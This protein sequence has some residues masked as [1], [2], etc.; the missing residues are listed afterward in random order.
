MAFKTPTAHVQPKR[1]LF[2]VKG[3]PSF[4][5]MIMSRLFGHLD[6]V[7]IYLDDIIIYA[8]TQEELYDKLQEV[9]E[10]LKTNNIKLNFDKCL[11]FQ[12]E[13][14]YLGRIVSHNKIRI[15]AQYIK[16]LLN[17]E[18]PKTKKELQMVLGVI[19][20]VAPWIPHLAHLSSPLHDLKQ[21]HAKW[22]WTPRH[23]EAFLKIK[24]LVKTTN[25]LTPPD[26]TKQF[27]IWLHVCMYV[28][29]YVICRN[30]FLFF[31]SKYVCMYVCML[32]IRASFYFFCVLFIGTSMY[33]CYPL[34]SIQVNNY[35]IH[36][37]F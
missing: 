22:K 35:T 31:F 21:K 17:L 6:K 13:I 9:F 34:T 5:Q 18:E 27:I 24:E 1:M 25:Y 14:E 28:C 36:T 4:Q 37:Y 11:F 8:N 7:Q 26:P 12:K 15:Q 29:M 19:G 2:G 23:T 10:I 30:N 20:W 32:F 16:K 33:V 3:A